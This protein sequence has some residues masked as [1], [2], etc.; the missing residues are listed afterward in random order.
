MNLITSL[1]L[2]FSF[3]ATVHGNR[4]SVKF[5]YKQNANLVY[6]EAFWVDEPCVEGSFLS[7][8][9]GDGFVK[10]KGE[11]K[12]QFEAAEVY[13]TFFSECNEAGATRTDLYL[14]DEDA[15]LVFGGLDNATVSISASGGSVSTSPCT[16]ETFTDEFGTYSFYS[17]SEGV[18]S[19]A[20]LSL[21]LFTKT[22]GGVYIERSNGIS[23]GPGFFTK[24]KSS[25]KCKEQLSSTFT[26]VVV[27]DIPFTVNSGF[28]FGDI[29]KVKEGY[30]ERFYYS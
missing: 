25:S 5:S 19:E 13:G 3:A 7:V 24:Y 8:F 16:L 27:N 9:A 11:K 23:K 12:I 21:N 1:V 30:S 15:E 18:S 10:V 26:N 20:T 6:S 4:D 28:G 29:C 22:L 2:V 14:F 17:C